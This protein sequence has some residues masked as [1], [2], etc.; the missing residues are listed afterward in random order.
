MKSIIRFVCLSLLL[1]ALLL[2]SIN[3]APAQ[4]YPR[5]VVRLVVPYPPGGGPDIISRIIIQKLAENWGQPVV[6]DNRPGAS[7]M[8]GAELVAKSAPDGYT[9][10]CSGAS[11]FIINP[12]MQSKLAYHPV[13]DFAPITM[14]GW[15]PYV[16]VVKPSLPVKSVQ[17]LVA[18]ARSK[19]GVLDC[20]TAGPATTGHLAL[21]L[22]KSMTGVD[23]V[24]VPYK[25]LNPGV[26]DLLAGRLSMMFVDQVEALTHINEGKLRALGMCSRQRSSVL[27]DIPPL[28]EAGLPGFEASPWLG[29]FAP[30]QTPKPIINKLNSEIVKAINAADIK[31]RLRVAGL[32]PLSGTPEQLA[33]HIETE[34]AK[35]VKILKRSAAKVD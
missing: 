6:I 12:L 1:G 19:P 29:Y 8:L 5:K 24:H 30:A 28:A 9:F 17:D 21:E 15:M 3:D 18:L 16:L 14:A 7:T 2:I 32:E 13:K 31:K 33:A 23:I 25:G 34:T 26:M 4:T 10:F 20:G 27:P 35:W 11:T 22:F